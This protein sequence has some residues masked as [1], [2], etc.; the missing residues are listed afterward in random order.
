MFIALKVVD[1]IRGRRSISENSKSKDA[2]STK[3]PDIDADIK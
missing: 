1:S 2:L 3:Q